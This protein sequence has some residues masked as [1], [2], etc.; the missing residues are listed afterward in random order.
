MGVEQ[1]RFPL[2]ATSEETAFGFDVRENPRGERALAV[3]LA[4]GLVAVKIRAHDGSTRYAICDERFEPIYLAAKTL[5]ELK[6]RFR[7][8][9]RAT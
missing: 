6:E 1:G 7:Q 8:K 5:A 4:A 9:G 3:A 2:D